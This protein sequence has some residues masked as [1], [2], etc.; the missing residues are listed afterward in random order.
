MPAMSSGVTSSPASRRLS[1]Q[2]KPFSRGERAQPGAPSTGALCLATIH[3][4][5][6]ACF[7]TSDSPA[8]IS[9]GVSDLR[10]DDTLLANTHVYGAPAAQSPVLHLRRTPGGTVFDH[11]ADSFERV[12]R[13]S[14]RWEPVYG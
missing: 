2:S 14:R 6:H 5:A 3:P 7:G 1:T 12:W 13:D 8:T 11:Y 10:S 9:L 4:C